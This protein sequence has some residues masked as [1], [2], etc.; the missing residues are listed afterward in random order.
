MTPATTVKDA[1]ERVDALEE[2]VAEREGRISDFERE[3][4]RLKARRGRL[5]RED[6]EG[7]LEGVRARLRALEDQRAEERDA[8]ELARAELEDAREAREEA[9]IR[10]QRARFD[11]LRGRFSQQAS[12]V[13]EL[14]DALAQKVTQLLET[15]RKLVQLY[16]VE[17]R[18]SPGNL[19]QVA[20]A[21]RFYVDDRLSDGP[22]KR[23][24]RRPVP[25]MPGRR[26]WSLRRL[27]GLH[28]ENRTQGDPD[29]D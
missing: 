12:E 2:E 26:G 11:G 23:L 6:E 28:N 5:R 24:F 27:L 17:D 19:S 14:A 22:Q 9:E 18:P 10:A 13:E 3:V 29:G 16:P 8:L 1:V 21:V 20:G 15:H 4:D 7:E 25:T